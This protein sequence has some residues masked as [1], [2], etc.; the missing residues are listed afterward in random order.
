VDGQVLTSAVHVKTTS[1]L[2][3][4][5]LQSPTHWL[6]SAA[7]LKPVSESWHVAQLLPGHGLGSAAQVPTRVGW[8]QLSQLPSQARLQQTP[9]AQ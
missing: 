9:S 6:G 5:A 4:H 1:L 8:A 2:A 3:V 7:Q